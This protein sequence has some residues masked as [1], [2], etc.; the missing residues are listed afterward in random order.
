MAP[1]FPSSR[2]VPLFYSMRVAGR[3]RRV[4]FDAELCLHRGVN[5]LAMRRDQ[6]FCLCGAPGRPPSL[7]SPSAQDPHR[8][9][10]DVPQLAH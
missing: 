9:L 1:P 7:R 6:S 8:S 4:R 10:G 3:R 5:C 2:L